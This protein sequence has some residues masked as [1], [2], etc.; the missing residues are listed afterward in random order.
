MHESVLL[1]AGPELA[2]LVQALKRQHPGRSA[3][4]IKRLYGLYLDYPEKPLRAAL[5]QALSYGLLDLARIEKMVLRA[6]ADNFFKLHDHDQQDQ[7]H[8]AR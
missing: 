8:Y 1:S 6:V 4:A 3:C 5:A 7:D 2:K